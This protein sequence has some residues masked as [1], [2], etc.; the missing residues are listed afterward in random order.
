MPFI[1]SS[2]QDIKVR[3]RQFSFH[4]SSNS[5][6][7]SK[8]HVIASRRVLSTVD[9]AGLLTVDNT[10]TTTHSTTLIRLLHGS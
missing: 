1:P 5:S 6:A 7:L 9:S 10:V 4:P 2:F 8:C 3:G